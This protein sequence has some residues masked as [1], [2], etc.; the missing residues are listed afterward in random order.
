MRKEFARRLASARKRKGW[1][2]SELARQ[3]ALHVKDGKFGRALV[4]GYERTRS[5]PRATQ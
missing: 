5:R 3:A 4:S 2:Q 1:N